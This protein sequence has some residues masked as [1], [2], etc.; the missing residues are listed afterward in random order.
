M[1]KSLAKKIEKSPELYQTFHEN[2]KSFVFP[3]G[4]INEG[5]IKMITKTYY[6]SYPRFPKI[7]LPKDFIKDT[8]EL[9]RI[10]L[11]RKSIRDFSKKGISAQELS[12][13]LFFSMG[14][15][16]DHQN[17]YRRVTPS[18]GA[19]YPIEMYPIILHSKDLQQ[20]VYHYNIKHHDL[21]QLKSGNFL[22]ELKKIINQNLLENASIVLVLSATFLRTTMK[23]G[24][25]GYRYIFLDAGHIAQ[26]VYLE[27]TKLNLGCC[28]IGGFLDQDLNELLDLGGLYESC[29][30]VLIIGVPKKQL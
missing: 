16:I 22:N 26:N 18:A 11:E 30:Y 24:N 7:S 12:K 1:E 4:K 8:G 27:A 3:K 2:T 29:I 14:N 13:I 17:N 9:E 5:F 20:G 21:E 6:K 19:R 10:F 15:F 23:Y 25:R 28:A